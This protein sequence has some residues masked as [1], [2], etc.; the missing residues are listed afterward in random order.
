MA[1]Q[2]FSYNQQQAPQQQ[3]SPPSGRATMN[4]ENDG[5]N[6]KKYL[7]IGGMLLVLIFIGGFIW[8][9]V[10]SP[11]IVTVSGTG[12]VKAPVESATI[13]FGLTSSA[14]S[15]S[16]AISLVESKVQRITSLLTAQGISD[17]D[18]A[19]SQVNV[20]PA[21]TL[22]QGATGY[23][24]TISMGAKTMHVSKVDDLI[25]LLYSN[26]ASVVSQPILSV[27]DRDT[28]E[29]QALDEAM[30][31][32]RADA[33]EIGNNNLK[34][35]R[36]IVLVSQQAPTGS[37]SITTKPDTLTGTNQPESLNTGVIK[38]RQTVTVSYKMW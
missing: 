21:S 20:V 18:I 2:N 36:K 19:E 10:N 22:V 12:E 27:E 13:S 23:Q 4:Y 24:A 15:S 16:E 1:A 6:F 11:M 30:Q 25:N 35:I 31:E 32:A 17:E 37:S 38:I 8:N 29:N 3:Q 5:F 7:V 14:S 34:F 33:K 9:W 26:G 28:L